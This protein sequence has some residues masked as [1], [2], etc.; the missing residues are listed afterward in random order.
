MWIKGLI[1]FAQTC[2]VSEDFMEETIFDHFYAKSCKFL[3]ARGWWGMGRDD[4][5][6]EYDVS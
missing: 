1:T 6:S 4:E 2:Q 3:W 5:I